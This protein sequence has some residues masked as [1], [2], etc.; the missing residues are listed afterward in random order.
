M[1]IFTC[2]IEINPFTHAKKKNKTNSSFPFYKIV[3]A[4]ALQQEF[5]NF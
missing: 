2:G 4:K 5:I 1:Y 3:F